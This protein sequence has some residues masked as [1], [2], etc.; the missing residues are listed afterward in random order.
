MILRAFVIFLVAL[1]CNCRLDILGNLGM[2]VQSYE[3]W[4]DMAQTLLGAAKGWT[5]EAGFFIN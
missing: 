1:L 3:D 4:E 2:T 5:N